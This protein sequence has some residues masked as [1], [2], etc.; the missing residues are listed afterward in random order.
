MAGAVDRLPAMAV[1]LNGETA[2]TKP[3]SARYS[4]RFHTPGPEI[5]CSSMM[6]CM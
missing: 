2:N 3:S 5:G 4:S 6:R 1:K